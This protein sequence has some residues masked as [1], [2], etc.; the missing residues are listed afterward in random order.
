MKIRLARKGD[1]D[2]IWEIFSKVIVK[3]DTYIFT[4]KTPKIHFQK[5]WM[6]DKMKTFVFSKNDNILGTY[7]IQPNQIGLGNHI[8]NCS[9]MVHPNHQNKGIGTLLC[10]HSLHK[11][12]KLK[13]TAMQFNIV[14][15]TNKNAIHLWQKFGFKIIGTTPKGFRHKTLGYVDTFIMYKSL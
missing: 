3:G 14:V 8:A 5:Y 10:K 2:K 9:Y 12:K 6:T 15:S 13:F 7:I 1:I 4:P 11:A